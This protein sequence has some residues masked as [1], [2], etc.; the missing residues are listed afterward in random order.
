MS[1]EFAGVML[2][3]DSLAINGSAFV[4]FEEAFRVMSFNVRSDESDAKYNWKLRKDRVVSI[5]RIHC[6]DLIGFQEPSKNQVND[7][8]EALSDFGR[9]SLGLND[10]R[11]AGFHDAILFRKSRFSLLDF[12]LFYLSATPQIPSR[13]WDAKFFRGVAWTKLFDKKKNKAFFLFNTH[14]DYHSRLARDESALLLREK[15]SL[16]AR[17]FPFVVTGDF[18]L[19]P[20]LGGKETYRLLTDVQ[21]AGRPLVDAQEVSLFPHH[22]P[23]GSWS[24][25]KEAG[26]PGS[27]PT[28]F[29]S[30]AKSAFIY[31]RFSQIPL[32]VSF[33]PIIFRSL[34]IWRF[35][36]ARLP[37]PQFV[38]TRS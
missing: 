3:V 34:P 18:N 17:E 19:F 15:I 12:G 9:F 36:R 28:I 24:G 11:D 25:F 35:L 1:D 7:L 16:I 23:T 37:K 20:E 31:M 38:G 2:L 22:G 14:F 4:G 27:S 30:M 33:L 6:A 10:G 29:L 8:E 13:G 32:T 21:I 5:I 26:S